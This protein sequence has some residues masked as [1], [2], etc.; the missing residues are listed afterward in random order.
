MV[1]RMEDPLAI[2]PVIAVPRMS[3]PVK[4]RA[5]FVLFAHVLAARQI[6]CSGDHF[7]VSSRCTGI[8]TLDNRK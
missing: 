2:I 3:V 6:V 8:G 5:S 7:E 4:D 1:V